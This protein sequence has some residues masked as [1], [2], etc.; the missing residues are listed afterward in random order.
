MIFFFP[1]AIFCNLA[2][3]PAVIYY[4]SPVLPFL[5]LLPFYQMGLFSDDSG[6][7][8]SPFG[9]SSPPLHLLMHDFRAVMLGFLK[10]TICSGD[11]QG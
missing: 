9:H 2:P 11:F 10:R 7:G 5:N 1:P 3:L 6:S 4:I 8:L